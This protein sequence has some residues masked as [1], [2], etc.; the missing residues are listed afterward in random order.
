MLST[1]VQSPLMFQ[2]F[3]RKDNLQ[4]HLI[5]H[6]NNRQ[7]Y[8]CTYEQCLKEYNSK[9]SYRVHVAIHQAKEGTKECPLCKQVY[10]GEDSLIRHIKVHAGSQ[11]IKGIMEKKHK[12]SVCDKRFFASKDCQRHMLTH[13]KE[14]H[15]ECHLCQMKFGRSDHLKR[16]MQKIH[17]NGEKEARSKSRVSK[18]SEQLSD[19]TA[20]DLTKS[21]QQLLSD[22]N[23]NIDAAGGGLTLSSADFGSA[24]SIQLTPFG[25]SSGTLSSQKGGQSSHDVMSLQ[26]QSNGI[27]SS[28]LTNKIQISPLLSNGS[29]ADSNGYSS[30]FTKVGSANAQWQPMLYTDSSQKYLITSD[31]PVRANS[32]PSTMILIPDG[33]PPLQ[34]V[35]QAQRT[36][37]ANLLDS[38][39][40]S[41]PLCT[42]YGADSLKV[43]NTFTPLYLN[44][45][46]SATE[47]DFLPVVYQQNF[48]QANQ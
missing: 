34:S 23:L 35:D 21:I 13:T 47:G 26:S 46:G 6:D 43:L 2:G 1:T 9:A 36:S 41:E 14:K 29:G 32:C 27:Q 12:C 16:H 38:G 44:A 28:P 25:T 48:T 7:L 24:S 20:A 33:Q 4:A 15:F 40:L 8:R 22:S 11:Q 39:V 30:S 31:T 42:D 45:D 5:V 3:A 37:T 10:D 19:L 17:P 18:K